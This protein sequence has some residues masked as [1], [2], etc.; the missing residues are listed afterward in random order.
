MALKGETFPI[1]SIL[2][3]EDEDQ[4]NI[5]SDGELES[6]VDSENDKNSDQVRK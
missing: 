6:E 4:D 2:I 5:F 3:T 1:Y